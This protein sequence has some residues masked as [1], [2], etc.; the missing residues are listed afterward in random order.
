[1]NVHVVYMYVCMYVCNCNEVYVC[2]VFP[3][4]ELIF[5]TAIYSTMAVSNRKALDF[6][7]WSVLTYE[8]YFFTAEGRSK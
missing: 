1:M 5:Y 7:L 4:A 6:I 3:L 2:Q 8:F